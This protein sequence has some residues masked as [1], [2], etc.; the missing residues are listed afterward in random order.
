V[1][2][3]GERMNAIKL[4]NGE[5]YHKDCVTVE[6]MEKGNGIEIG[7]D[8]VEKGAECAECSTLLFGEE[9]QEVEIDDDDDDDD[10]AKDIEK[11]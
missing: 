3:D 9:L 10:E 11:K 7:V 4:K 2:K 5:L 6:E 8:D 1:I